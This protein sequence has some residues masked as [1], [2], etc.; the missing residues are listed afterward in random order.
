MNMTEHPLYW[1]YH[2]M[3]AR[4]TSPSHPRWTSYGGRGIRVCERWLIDFWTFVADMGERPEG[5]V[6]DRIDND[7]NYE[8]GNCRWATYSE[9]NANKR[10]GR[11]FDPDQCP[12]GH[13]REEHGF[14]DHRGALRCRE[15]IKGY[16]STVNRPTTRAGRKGSF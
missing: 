6:L 5:M 3:K 12:H 2:Q 4:C 14:R 1:T 8:P 16:P 7:G 9:S 10:P 15:C 11:N 13:S